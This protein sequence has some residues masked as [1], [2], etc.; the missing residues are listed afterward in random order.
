LL[1]AGTAHS[2]I[3][4]LSPS[5]FGLAHLHHFYEFRITN[6]R[7]P[8]AAAVARSVFQLAYTSLFGMYATFIFIRTGSLPAVIL[9]HTF[10]NYMGLPRVWGSLEPY[11]MCERR[12]QSRISLTVWTGLYYVLLVGGLCTWCWNMYPLTR[13]LMALAEL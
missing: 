5:V 6:P 2:R 7:V 10:C 13:S 4:Y 12:S 8:L 9:I 3:I 11:W 1:L